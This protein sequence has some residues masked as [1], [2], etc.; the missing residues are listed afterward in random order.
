MQ[1][2]DL[3]HIWANPTSRPLQLEIFNHGGGIQFDMKDIY[4]RKLL[5]CWKLRFQEDPVQ[6]LLPDFPF[7][8]IRQRMEKF[9]GSC[10]LGNQCVTTFAFSSLNSWTDAELQQP[11][12]EFKTPLNCPSF[13]PFTNKSTFLPA[14]PTQDHHFPH[15]SPALSHTFVSSSISSSCCQS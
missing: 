2:W 15:S 11:H 14:G 6:D 13:R 7:L 1:S 8:G 5:F 10:S 4:Q 3:L 12:F 9:S